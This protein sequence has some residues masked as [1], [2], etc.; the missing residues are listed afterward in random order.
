[1]PEKRI[2]KISQRGSAIIAIL[3]LLLGGVGIFFEGAVQDKSLENSGDMTLAGTAIALQTVSAVWIPLGAYLTVNAYKTARRRKKLYLALI[4]SAI[5]Y[6]PLYDLL[7]RGRGNVGKS[8]PLFSLCIV[9]AM[10]YFYEK[11]KGYSIKSMV[12]KIAVTVSGLIWCGMLF[13]TGGAAVI[14]L[15]VLYTAL[16]EKRTAMLFSSAALLSV[17]AAVDP[18][19]I[20]S[21]FGV[22]LV[23]FLEWENEK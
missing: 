17:C 1:M 11:H 13:V 23:S 15:C 3:L 9:V 20:F 10:L 7:E 5:I 18:V 12:V 14:L 6:E 8:N 21:F 2:L 4:L 22:I 19:L 16:W